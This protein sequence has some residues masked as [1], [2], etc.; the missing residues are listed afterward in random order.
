MGRAFA[1]HAKGHRFD[2]GTVHHFLGYHI[3][4]AT[5]IKKPSE[6]QCPQVS[7]DDLVTAAKPADMIFEWSENL[8]ADVI[9][10]VTHGPSHVIQ[11]ANF[12]LLDAQTY[13]FEAVFGFGVRLLPL[14]HYSHARGWRVLCRRTGITSEDVPMVTGRALTMLGRQ[15]EVVEELQIAASKLAPWV[16]VDKTDNRVFCSGLVQYNFSGSSVPFGAVPAGNATPIFLFE[17]PGTEVVC[18][19]A[20]E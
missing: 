18:K 3:R 6:I 11:L 13:E 14:S 19:C 4:M 17:D 12:P 5:S 8:I 10:L 2:P 15:Y 1:W 16:H 7:W 20:P 9:E